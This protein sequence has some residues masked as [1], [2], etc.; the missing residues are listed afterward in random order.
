MTSAIDSGGPDAPR[1]EDH[2][3]RHRT[4]AA[5]ERPDPVPQRGQPDKAFPFLLV[6]LP[7]L[8]IMAVALVSGLAAL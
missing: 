8:A 4:P 7:M 5:P 2:G 3:I 1:P 6:I